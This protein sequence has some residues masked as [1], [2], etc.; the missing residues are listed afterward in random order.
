[1][2]RGGGRLIDAHDVAQRYIDD[3]NKGAPLTRRLKVVVAC[4]NGTAGIFAPQVLG[5]MGCDVVPLDCELDYTFPNYNPNPED[6]KM[7][8]AASK[9]VAQ[10]EADLALCFDGDGDRCGVIDNEGNAIFAD[11]VGVLLARHFAATAR[12]A[13]FIAD[14]KSTGLFESDPVLKSLGARCEYWKT[15]HSYMKRHTAER[16]RSPALR[17][18][19]IIFSSRRL[20][21]AMMTGCSPLLKSCACWS[22]AWKNDGGSLPGTC[23]RPGERPPCRPI[24]PMTSNTKL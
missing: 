2:E 12:N 24:A 21:G 22:S 6:L 4:G 1:M 10:H 14:V 9:A 18:R 13:L 20:A 17:N 23:R 16:G 3:L 19:A 8:A 15:G 11:K 7:L 5:A